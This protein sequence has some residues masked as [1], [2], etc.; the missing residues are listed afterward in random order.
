M[1]DTALHVQGIYYHVDDRVSG[2]TPA[3]VTGPGQLTARPTSLTPGLHILYTFATDGQ[4]STSTNTGAQSSPLISNIIGTPFLVLPPGTP[5]LQSV[6]I[7]PPLATL[8]IGYPLQL[9]ATGTFS[10][11]TTRIIS[12]EVSWS[13]SNAAAAVS[14]QSGVITGMAPGS[15]A[16]TASFGPLSASAGVTAVSPS[17]AVVAAPSGPASVSGQNYI[18][19]VKVT[20]SGNVPVSGVA[21]TSVLLNSTPALPSRP[22]IGLLAPGASSTF[23]FTFPGTAGAHGAI[24]SLRTRGTYN[25]T[26]PGGATQAET[27]T[28]GGRLA[29][30]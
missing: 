29:L 10:D 16:F 26:L 12:G 21:L 7:T 1:E 30:P 24:A 9:S 8:V 19:N 4:D 22:T 28:T 23:S 3:A 5:I 15:T 27:F 13:N 6:S 17:Y 20:N 25:V 2:W 11:G 14:D 18:V